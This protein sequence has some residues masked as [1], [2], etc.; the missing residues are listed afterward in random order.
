VY[1]NG[2]EI[3]QHRV[4]RALVGLDTVGPLSL[5]QGTNVLVFKVVNESSG[6]VGCVRL[7]DDTGRPVPNIRVKLSPEP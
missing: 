3:Y 6:W 7:V 4:A 2:R 1:L 5:R